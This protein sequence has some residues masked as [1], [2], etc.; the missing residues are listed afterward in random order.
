MIN[1]SDIVKAISG[2]K[3]RPKVQVAYLSAELKKKTA[4]DDRI[5]YNTNVG[6][7]M[8]LMHTCVCVY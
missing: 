4:P 7:N 8:C 6:I 5:R 2:A 3:N 1:I